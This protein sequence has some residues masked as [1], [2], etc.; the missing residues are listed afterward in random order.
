MFSLTTYTRKYPVAISVL[1]FNDAKRNECGMI[2]SL[3]VVHCIKII[4]MPSPTP[5]V[6]WSWCNRRRCCGKNGMKPCFFIHFF[7]LTPAE[8]L[9]HHVPWVR[10][11]KQTFNGWYIGSKIRMCWDWLLNVVFYLVCSQEL[12]AYGVP[13]FSWDMFHFVSR[14]WF[15]RCFFSLVSVA[16]LTL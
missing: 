7:Y 11:I 4:R 5:S 8:N 15:S 14:L 13:D 9:G 3:P 2:F 16:H 1:P 6:W 12:R 10:T